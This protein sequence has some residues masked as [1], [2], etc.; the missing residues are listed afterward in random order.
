MVKKV[1]S[2]PLLLLVGWLATKLSEKYAV[3]LD[4]LDFDFEDEDG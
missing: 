3:A 4:D 1:L 2:V